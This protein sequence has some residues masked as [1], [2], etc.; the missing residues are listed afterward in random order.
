M[1]GSHSRRI[2]LPRPGGPARR[3]SLHAPVAPPRWVRVTALRR[4]TEDAVTLTVAPEDGRTLPF[5]A[6][7][8]LTH[9]FT[10]D[11]AEER[12]AY[13]LS[14][15]EGGALSCTIKLL[16]DGRVSRYIAQQLK[17]GDRYRVIGPGGDF[18]LDAGHS[19]PLVLLAGGSG[20]TPVISLVETALAQQPTRPVRLV[21]V[22]RD[23]AHAIFHERLE[24][25][26]LRYAA[27]EY[28][29]VFTADTGRPDAATLAGLLRPDAQGVVYLC[30][31]QALMDAADAG[32]RAAGFD[33][34][35]IRRER[36][37][38]APRHQPRPTEPQ[39]IFFRRSER[40]VTQQPG[41][42]ILEAGTRAG[43]RLDF[44]CTVGG[45]GHCKVRI[46]DGQ[47]RL[48][49]PNCLTPEERSAGY[50]LACSACATTPITVDA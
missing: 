11:G 25:L 49:E 16:P 40:T 10:I 32:L 24:A 7:Q 33:P 26:A 43:L 17:V 21:T 38:P 12:R 41:E 23:R 13:S 3:W 15:A 1:L 14:S 9:C 45:C 27:L 42:T 36:F 48:D 34:A 8:Y 6:G 18:T 47:V 44:S 19:G 5:R 37:V 35:R 50:T 2:I 28:T 31:P 29:P 4:E 39:D 22:N 46:V 20:I 30:G